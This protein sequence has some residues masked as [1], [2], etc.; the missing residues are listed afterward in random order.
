MSNVSMSNVSESSNNVS[1]DNVSE[2][3]KPTRNMSMRKLQTLSNRTKPP[4]SKMVRQLIYMKPDVKQMLVETADR[5][6]TTLT[7]II[8]E[9]I[10]VYVKWLRAADVREAREEDKQ[11]MIDRREAAKELLWQIKHERELAERERRRRKIK[12][13]GLGYKYGRMKGEPG[14]RYIK[15]GIY[16]L[17]GGSK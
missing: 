3:P 6:Q 10:L 15:R 13:L 2:I 1:G 17:K 16:N 5:E 4:Y 11:E 14:R 12:L 9:A 7:S 8:Q